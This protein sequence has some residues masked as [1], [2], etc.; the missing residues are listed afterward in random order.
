MNTIK[1]YICDKEAVIKAIRTYH[2]NLEN[3]I[4][5]EGQKINYMSLMES[6]EKINKKNSYSSKIRL[7]KKVD[8]RID[9]DIVF[10]IRKMRKNKAGIIVIYL[11]LKN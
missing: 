1:I 9:E 5:L 6:I 7:V 8:S 3:I 11:K 4:K 2:K 10:N